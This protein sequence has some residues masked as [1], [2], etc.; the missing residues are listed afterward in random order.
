L[1]CA[2]TAFLAICLTSLMQ[3]RLGQLEGP[4]RVPSAP[5]T[6]LSGAHDE[7]PYADGGS[8]EDDV[9]MD[10]GEE[11]VTPVSAYAAAADDNAEL[12]RLTEDPQ[13]RSRLLEF[14]RA[15]GSPAAAR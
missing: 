12:A 13:L 10:Q 7:A 2:L 6:G 15:Q 9:A 5:M 8:G 11:S 4:G 1:D 14:L 3:S